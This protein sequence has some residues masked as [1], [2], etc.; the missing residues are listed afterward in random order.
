MDQPAEQLSGEVRYNKCDFKRIGYLSLDSNQSSDFK[1]RELKKVKLDVTCCFARLSLHHNHINTK[2]LYNQ[3]GL[4]GVQ[5]IGEVVSQFPVKALGPLLAEQQKQIVDLEDMTPPKAIEDLQDLDL[6]PQTQ[7]ELN[8][9][10]FFKQQAAQNEDF[11]EAQH[12]KEKIEHIK[13]ISAQLR[14]LE[15]QK[16]TAVLKEDFQRAAKIKQRI[17]QLKSGVTSPRE[18]EA[19]GN[20]RTRSSDSE[21]PRSGDRSRKE[22]K[23]VLPDIRT[24]NN[25]H[26]DVPIRTKYKQEVETDAF[27]DKP[28]VSQRNRAQPTQQEDEE[29]VIEKPKRKKSTAK[30][31]RTPSIDED[32]PK[33]RKSKDETPFDERPAKSSKK[34]AL[35]YDDEPVQSIDH[36]YANAEDLKEP[37]LVEDNS[38]AKKRADKKKRN[39]NNDDVEI[40][41]KEHDDD[42]VVQ[43]ADIPDFQRHL[44]A[45][46]KEIVTE[47]NAPEELPKI[48]DVSQTVTVLGEYVTQC[49]YSNNIRAYRETAVKVI[50][51]NLET[52]PGTK[53]NLMIAILRYLKSGLRDKITHVYLHC[54]TLFEKLLQLCPSVKKKDMNVYYEPV[55]AALFDRTKDTNQKIHISAIDALLYAATCKVIGPAPIYQM[56]IK[57]PQDKDDK[58]STRPLLSR[59]L[60]LRKLVDDYGFEN[61]GITP[62]DVMKLCKIGFDN[63]N[64]DVRGAAVDLTKM[65]YEVTGD[66]SLVRKYYVHLEK[67]KKV[68]YDQIDQTIQPLS[69]RSETEDD[70]KAD[71][72]EEEVP[73]DRCEFCNA[74]PFAEGEAQVDMHL[75]TECPWLAI[76][77]LCV[78]MVTVPEMNDHMKTECEQKDNGKIC[79]RCGLVIP[80]QKYEQHVKSKSCKPLKPPEKAGRC[81]ICGEDTPPGL[82]G[83]KQHI[84]EPPYCPKKHL[85]RPPEEPQEEEVKKK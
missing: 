79:G 83:M 18:Q 75:V 26:D 53:R 14:E 34:Q 64:Q 58:K 62:H 37:T 32:A 11:A 68:L 44:I 59:L 67:T 46:I 33:A 71:I 56:C 50:T 51:E 30:K 40:K 63:S 74:G 57:I 38:M 10:M 4:I 85:N 36:D 27:D 80:K 19:P 72:E 8:K 28:A 47:E 31:A 77:P 76:C 69:A 21:R 65:V 5:F 1:A 81:P 23:V 49:L 29:D 84:L 2:N 9:L 41:Q 54:I 7:E 78:Q 20:V 3:V 35:S 52:I 16:Q 43:E 66:R 17:D 12:L 15:R 48:E 22:E 70:Q 25:A 6:D 13:R 24:R 39:Y 42:L 61:S 45:Q 60:I 55:L 73:P 82:E